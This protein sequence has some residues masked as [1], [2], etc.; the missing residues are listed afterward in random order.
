MV[1]LGHDL[2]ST[3]SM[4]ANNIIGMTIVYLL[5]GYYLKWR[6]FTIRAIN[7]T[8]TEGRA[9]VIVKRLTLRSLNHQ[10]NSNY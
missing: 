7:K 6:L 4:L 2:T 9:Q 3:L 8:V 5:P 1:L 10:R